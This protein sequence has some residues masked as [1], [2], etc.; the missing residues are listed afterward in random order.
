MVQAQQQTDDPVLFLRFSTEFKSG[1]NVGEIVLVIRTDTLS[2]RYWTFFTLVA[3]ST[4]G[5][6]I[7]LFRIDGTQTRGLQ[8][9]PFKQESQRCTTRQIKT[10]NKT[11]AERKEKRIKRLPSPWR[12][13]NE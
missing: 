9:C 11:R 2:V 5:R 8:G 3:C 12:F 10:L 4:K 1:E 13:M 7:V 6:G